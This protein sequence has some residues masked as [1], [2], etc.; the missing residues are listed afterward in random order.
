MKSTSLLTG[1]LG[2]SAW[3]AAAAHCTGFVYEN[4]REFVADGDF[5]GDGRQD[6]VIVDRSKGKLRLGY[7]LVAG[8]YTWV[9]ARPVGF[10]NVSGL[11]VGRLLASNH[12]ALAL[13]SADD[14]RTVVL[15]AS[16]P[17]AAKTPVEV[18][19][20]VLGP[21]VVLAV[22]IGGAGNTP[23]DDLYVG[24]IYNADPMN[25]ASLFRATGSAFEHLTD[26][27]LDHP[28]AR[29]NRLA[30]K[31]GGPAYG[32]VLEVGDQSSTLRALDLSSGSPRP[33]LSLGEL[34]SGAGYVVGDF[35]RGDGGLREFVFYQPGATTLQVRSVKE[36]S[37]GEFQPGKSAQFDLGQPVWQLFALADPQTPKLLAIFG[38]GDHT[39]GSA[40]VFAFDGVSAPQPVQSLT[41]K[42]GEFFSGAAP[43][44]NGFLLFSAP[45]STVA[46]AKSSAKYQFFD[47]AG[48][49]NADA[50]FGSLASLADSD[51]HTIPEIHKLILARLDVTEPSQ[52]KPYTNTIPGTGVKYVMVPIPGGEFLM[53]SSPGEAGHKPDEA[54]AHKVRISPFWM[55]A[56][57]VTWDAYELFMYPDDE[58]RLREAFGRD[59]YADKLADAV[60]RPSKPYA[61]MTFGMGKRG[62]PAISMTQHGANK[63]CQ[64]LSAKT[65]HFY[66]LPTEAEWEYAARA[67]TQTA[68]FFG[69]DPA[70]LDQ[71]AW[72]ED[73]SDF[74]YAKV[75][76]KKPNPWGLYDILGNVAEWCLDQ[77]DPDYYKQFEHL[78]AQD[79]WNRATKPYPHVVRGGSYDDPP[80]KLRC[81]ARLGS[82]RSWKMRDPQLPKSTWYFTDAQFVGFRIVRPLQVPPP[83]ELKRYWISGVEKE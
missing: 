58:Q 73:N 44:E 78:L 19:L 63:F 48:M 6:L 26:L 10:G 23:L 81:A 14:N 77:Y 28:L 67:G 47:F 74:K 76:R 60:T 24:S 70:Q 55:G 11:A 4:E 35:H 80:E 59:E 40:G 51:E 22:D 79:P 1:L 3:L 69:D 31:D 72:Y 52:M 45:I 46:S 5:D 53:G 32:V 16:D 18:S 34:P 54:P 9:D 13:T 56:F 68:Y 38:E 65:G 64:W 42:E 2:V 61:D 7:Q 25:Q 33:V 15:D 12:D 8:R 17:A 39:G 43:L 21:N 41:P 27:P 37:P 71:Y 82:D 66:R 62:Y 83:E 36:P 29:P 50:P 57:E 20:A 30:L 75:G 49:T